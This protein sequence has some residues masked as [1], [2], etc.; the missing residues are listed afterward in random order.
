MRCKVG[1]PDSSGERTGLEKARDEMKLQEIPLE[2]SLKQ[3]LYFCN[4][5][6][7]PVPLWNIVTVHVCNA[8][9]NQPTIATLIHTTRQ[10][11]NDGM[12]SV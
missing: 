9:R 4:T 11:A 1:I 10:R 5:V 3:M 2:L 7:N 8:Q 6:I 12:D